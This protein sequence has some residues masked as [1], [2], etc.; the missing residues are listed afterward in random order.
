MSDDDTEH[1][2]KMSKTGRDPI[3]SW[4]AIFAAGSACILAIVIIYMVLFQDERA[5]DVD[6]PAVEQTDKTQ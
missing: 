1:S 3:G 2:T 6:S 5:I 4:L